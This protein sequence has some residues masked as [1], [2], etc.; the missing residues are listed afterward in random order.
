[1]ART[2]R[3]M[4]DTPDSGSNI[5]SKRDTEFHRVGE[6]RIFAL[7]SEPCSSYAATLGPLMNL[8]R[9]PIKATIIVYGFDRP[10]AFGLS[11]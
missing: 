10:N 2:N 3:S 1:M 9:A 4:R 7:Q 11:R 8:A 6:A 5:P